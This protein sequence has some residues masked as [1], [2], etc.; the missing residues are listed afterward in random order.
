[1]GFYGGPIAAPFGG[2]WIQVDFHGLFDLS[3]VRLM[4]NLNWPQNVEVRAGPENGL[5]PGV[6]KVST[7]LL[8]EEISSYLGGLPPTEN[9]DATSKCN[10]Q[11]A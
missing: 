1:M 11:I 6:P 9:D 4:L 2:Q 7:D 8:L 10:R 3:K 5:V